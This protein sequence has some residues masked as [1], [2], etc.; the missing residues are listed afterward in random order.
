MNKY[1]PITELPSIESAER[2]IKDYSEWAKTAREIDKF[3]SAAQWELTVLLLEYY[4][5]KE[6]GQS[7][8]S[9]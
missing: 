1:V 5:R 2:M 4:V 8:E 7:P 9:P 6:S 3:G